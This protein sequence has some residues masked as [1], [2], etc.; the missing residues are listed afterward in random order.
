MGFQKYTRGFFCLLFYMGRALQKNQERSSKMQNLYSDLQN[1]LDRE[2]SDESDP[3]GSMLQSYFFV[4]QQEKTA[5]KNGDREVLCVDLGGTNLKIRV[6]NV[7]E[8]GE[9]SL[10]GETFMTP[11]PRVDESVENPSSIYHWISAE[12]KKYFEQN[13]GLKKQAPMPGALTFSFPL[14]NTDEGKVRIVA[15]TKNF[16]AWKKKAEKETS[17]KKEEIPLDEINSRVEGLVR[18]GV[19]IN[20][21]MATLLSARHRNMSAVLGVVLGTGTNGAYFEDPSC[22]PSLK[23]K[24]VTYLEKKEN[25]QPLEKKEDPANPTTHTQPQSPSRS[26]LVALNTEWG[27]LST[28]GVQAY[29]DDIDVALC[30]NLN[31]ESGYFTE[32]MIGGM[33][34]EKY[35]TIS[36]R[37]KLEEIL[38]ADKMSEYLHLLTFTN[39][40]IE[41]MG[42]VIQKVQEVGKSLRADPDTVS[43]M[44]KTADLVVE[45]AKSRREDILTAYIAAIICRAENT[46]AL[47]QDST[48][49]VGLN[50][51]GFKSKRLMESLQY[52]VKQLLE[53]I[54]ISSS[55][56]KLVFEYDPDAS[57]TGSAYAWWVSEKEEHP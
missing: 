29:R 7:T 32:K 42:Q 19:I 31:E 14:A 11:V 2:L 10:Q 30:S 36:I 57:L 56:K 8:K 54:C 4:D 52:K 37:K 12:I 55:K 41:D 53:D 9:V 3:A 44:I 25:S 24:A 17:E 40:E 13:P 20:D 48:Y 27:G 18:F 35:T 33:Y 49:F 23:E 47:K 22:I 46:P 50:G 51:S 45:E 15:Y 38:G 28:P 16:Y 34:F 1:H 26:T 5:R 6:A 21:A 39:E 43:A